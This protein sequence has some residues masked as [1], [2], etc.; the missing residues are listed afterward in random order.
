MSAGS[1]TWLSSPTRSPTSSSRSPPATDF[2]YCLWQWAEGRGDRSWV[3]SV[4]LL[5]LSDSCPC[6]AGTPSAQGC[7]EDQVPLCHAEG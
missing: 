5:T 1:M 3:G 6:W 4:A 7:P 2:N